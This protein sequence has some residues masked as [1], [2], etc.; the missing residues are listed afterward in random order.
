MSKLKDKWTHSE[1]INR[2]EAKQKEKMNRDI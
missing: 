1:Y 2:L